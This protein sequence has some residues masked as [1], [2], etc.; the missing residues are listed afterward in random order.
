MSYRKH[1]FLWVLT[2]TIAGIFCCKRKDE[3]ILNQAAWSSK[4]PIAIPFAQRNNQKNAK[5]LVFNPSFETGKIYY[6]KSNIKS[7]DVTGWKK[8]GEIVQW[9]DM[10]SNRFRNDEVFDGTHAIKIIRKRADE[11]EKLGVGIVSDYIKVIPGNYSL[12]LYLRLENICP[13]RARLGTKMYDAV[14]IRLQFFDKN[15]IEI[16]GHEYNPFQQ[17]KIDNAFQSLNLTNYWNISQ[18]GW[19]MING[20]SAKYPFFNG[21]IPDETRY[22]K[23]FIGLKGTGTLWVDNVNF[24]YTR[25][26]FTFLERM[27]PYFDSAYTAHDLLMPQPKQ[28]KKLTSTTFYKGDLFPVILVP[29]NPQQQ[30]LFAAQEIKNALDDVFT[31][32]LKDYS[33]HDVKIVFGTTF[34]ENDSNRFVISLGK[35][36]LF[37]EYKSLLPDSLIQNKEQGYFITQLKEAPH[38]VFLCGSDKEGNYNAALTFNQLINANDF[39]YHSAE[40]VDYPD[41]SQRGFLLHEFNGTVAQL[42][43]QLQT[44]ADYKLNHAYFEIYENNLKYYPF[45]KIKPQYFIGHTS[46]MVD[47]L[48]FSFANK[49]DADYTSEK[50]IF[51]QKTSFIA[52]K[53]AELNHPGLTNVLIKGDYLQPYH[54]SNPEWIKFNANE[55]ISVNLQKYHI[56]LLK[57]LYN[58][59]NV[60]LEFMPPWSRLDYINMGMGQAEFYFRD[61][62]INISRTIPIYWTGGSNCSP[63]IDYAE[64]FRMKKLVKANPVL[65]DNS[66]SYNLLRFKNEDINSYYAGKLRMLSLFEPLKA[67]YPDNFYQKNYQGKIL[68]NIDSLTPTNT[69]KTLS[70]ANYYWNTKEYNADKSIWKLL[71]KIYGQENAKNLVYFNDAYFG[72][73]EICQKMKNNGINNKN[74]R[75]ANAFLEDL[76]YYTDWLN[77]KMPEKKLLYEL[78]QLRNDL[79]DEYQSITSLQEY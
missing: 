44:L 64:W 79:H 16:S 62:T 46:A 14:N 39:I 8:T 23:I 24:S 13:N 48:K 32:L 22:V 65:F 5:N 38:I 75:I 15:K 40:I 67:D 68:L 36:M 33:L 43:N 25:Q 41:F 3:V 45:K 1:I 37:D 29:Q 9:V 76:D 17:T 69:L 70:A 73:K 6:E 7:F 31:G 30:T 21:D 53:I 11:T 49:F 59:L 60:K 42:K 34:K 2:L 56:D 27:K 77:K 55:D 28:I 74:S 26:N 50:N 18:F 47:L 54:S 58:N 66:L 71:V 78:I 10:E 12:N 20:Q 19:G 63:T 35:T 72:L 52:D 51:H 4:D 57:K 61:L